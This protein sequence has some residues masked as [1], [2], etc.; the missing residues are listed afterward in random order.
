MRLTAAPVSFAASPPPGRPVRRSR[1]R[2]LM[3]ISAAVLLHA[4]PFIVLLKVGAAAPPP[5]EPQA[6]AVELIRFDASPVQAPSERAPGEEQAQRAQNTPGSRQPAQKV[7]PR[8]AAV[9]TP[10]AALA[11]PVQP[12]TSPAAQTPQ[13]PSPATTA[14]L[15]RPAPPAAQASSTPQEWRARVLAHLDRNKRY[16]A[17]AERQRQEGVVHLRFT[18]DRAGRVLSSSIVRGSGRPMLD[19]EALAMLQRAQPL[20]PPPKDEPGDV[21]EIMTHVDFFTRR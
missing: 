6:I 7:V 4:A 20:P 10:S 12:E 9:D 21:I 11:S 16:P 2:N 1:R 18:M 17:I 14:P 3:A 19:R 5:P 13:P 8:L 15:A